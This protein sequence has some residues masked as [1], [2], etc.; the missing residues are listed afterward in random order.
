MSNGV[1]PFLAQQHQRPVRQM[2][3]WWYSNLAYQANKKQQD[4]RANR[5]VKD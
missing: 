5:R 1:L 4:D 3:R 2:G